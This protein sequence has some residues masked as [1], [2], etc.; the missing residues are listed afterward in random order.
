MDTKITLI[1]HLDE[2]RKRLL[3]SL[4]AFL[5][6]SVFSFS[7]SARLLVMLR[8]PASIVIG[9][10]FFF[11]PEEAFLVNMRLAMLCGLIISMPVIL[12]QAWLFIRPA[13]EPEQ[14]RYAQGFILFSS[15][16]FL[17]GCLFAYFVLLAPAMR[18]LMSFAGD[19]LVPMISA[20]KYISFVSVI[21]GACGFIFQMPVL[22]FFLTRLRIINS[23]LLRRK[24]KYALVAIFVAAAV[25]TPTTDV[26]NMLLLA[27]PILLLYEVSI[28][29]S[30]LSRP[31]IS[32]N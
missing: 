32:S 19:G 12:S 6:C 7:Q 17:C 28:W 29:V 5:V 15:L 9:R 2:L 11:A 10:L 13:L 25:I 1:E 22:S 18:F 27:A 30:Y 24:Y 20:A 8:Q 31:K 14:R 4:A 16:F 26:V 23:Q 21:I 3:I